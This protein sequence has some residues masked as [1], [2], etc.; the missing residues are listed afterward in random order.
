MEN[1]MNRTMSDGQTTSLSQFFAGIYTWMTVG[2][3]LSAAFAYATLN[4]PLQSIIF[5]NP[6]IF[7]GINAI[8][9]A[10]LFGVQIFIKKLPAELSRALF[11]V[12]AAINGMFLSIYFLRYDLSSIVQTF[13]ISAAIF[14]TLAIIGFKTK[15]DLSSWKTVLFA[16][17]WGVFISSLVNMFLQNTMVDMM[18]SAIAIL[19][20]CG[21]TVY[22]NQTYKKLYHNCVNNEDSQE[23][24]ITLG[25]LHMYINFIMIFVNLLKFFGSRD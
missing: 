23:K 15:K 17:M 9:L 6:V 5:G 12:Y 19:V 8:E 2:L 16:G 14:G 1:T 13:I 25:A 7:Y 18:V 10:I 4:T 21:L 24:I 22:D 20:F 3:L 11:F